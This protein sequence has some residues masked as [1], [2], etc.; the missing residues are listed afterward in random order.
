[1]LLAPAF[2][3]STT[4]AST[5]DTIKCTSIGAFTPALRSASQTKGPTVRFGT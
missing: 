1:M 5:G 4:K 2:A 3:K